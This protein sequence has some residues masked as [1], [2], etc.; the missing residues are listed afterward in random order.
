VII[1]WGI[2]K[3][4][5]IR[6]YG[7]A[8]SIVLAGGK[9]SALVNLSN[10][11]GTNY[12]VT[13]DEWKSKIELCDKDKNG[14]GSSGF[15]LGKYT[16]L[17]VKRIIK[18]TVEDTSTIFADLN[19]NI[20]PVTYSYKFRIE[21]GWLFNEKNGP[22]KPATLD[23]EVDSKIV[24][25]GNFVKVASSGTAS[26]TF[27]KGVWQSWARKADGTK[28]TILSTDQFSVFGA[29]IDGETNALTMTN[30]FAEIRIVGGE[31]FIYLKKE[32][33]EIFA[34]EP[35][36]NVPTG[37]SVGLY[38]I[39]YEEWR[40]YVTV[41]DKGTLLTDGEILKALND[42]L[43]EIYFYT[44]GD[45][46]PVKNS[47]PELKTIN[48]TKAGLN[49]LTIQGAINVNLIFNVQRYAKDQD[50]ETILKSGRSLTL[51]QMVTILKICN[52]DGTILSDAEERALLEKSTITATNGTISSDKTYFW[53]GVGETAITFRTPNFE[54]FVIKLNVVNFVAEK[55]AN[56]D[57]VI[58]HGGT[59][60]F[61]VWKSWISNGNNPLLNNLEISCT[62]ANVDKDKNLTNVVGHLV[63][64][65]LDNKLTKNEFCSVSFT[66]LSTE[67]AHAFD[68]DK[69][70]Y[71]TTGAIGE[72]GGGMSPKPEQT[73]F[74]ISGNIIN[75]HIKIG[76][77]HLSSGK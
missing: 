12:Q 10:G 7:I 1:K 31:A 47:L 51:A 6:L 65:F 67:T 59:I 11:G 9:T 44:E 4:S 19:G 63:I 71:N 69:R 18:G 45:T 48:F 58:K 5:I 39:T 37:T 17:S 52:L 74:K 60:P 27:A 28:Y 43:T 33:N 21:I 3:S 42:P 24:V 57:I 34:L 14:F 23:F 2:N 29:T 54:T 26:T 8:S 50:K 53:S 62:N 32:G 25:G 73:K 20:S 77:S 56:E 40:K 70:A 64:S 46:N 38:S 41:S 66:I 61:N 30:N 36:I 49:Y 35:V 75:F 72:L 13:Y 76:G 55:I 16:I 15:S 68:F 22:I